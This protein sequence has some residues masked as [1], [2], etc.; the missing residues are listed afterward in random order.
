MFPVRLFSRWF[1]WRRQPAL[2]HLH[3]VIYTRR[4]CHLCQLAW[5][6]LQAAQRRHRFTLEATDVDDDPELAAKYGG[7][8]PVITV[9]GKLRFRGAVNPALLARL[10][11]AEKEKAARVMHHA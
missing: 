11:H 1:R 7:F 4:G 3:F 10:L 8:V 2:D 9:N 6:Q 5:R